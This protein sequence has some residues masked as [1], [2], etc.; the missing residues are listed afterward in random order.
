MANG[1]IITSSGSSLKIRIIVIYMGEL[2]KATLP[3]YG[4]FNRN[5]SI[6]QATQK[7]WAQHVKP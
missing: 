4:G 2:G 1:G 3:E 7:S 5:F 6:L